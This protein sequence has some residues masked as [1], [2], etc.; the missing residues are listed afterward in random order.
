MIA[1]RDARDRR[2][3][4]DY[5]ALTINKRA[6][7]ARARRHRVRA[8]H[9]LKS[10]SISLSAALRPLMKSIAAPG[11]RLSRNAASYPRACDA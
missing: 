2:V 4:R 10:R 8:V 6:S 1:M 11:S 9:R 3:K 7:T 5:T